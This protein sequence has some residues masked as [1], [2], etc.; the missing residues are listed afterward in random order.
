[1]APIMPGIQ[2]AQL[3]V[4]VGH[5]PSSVNPGVSEL[6]VLA[7]RHVTW[8]R[9]KNRLKPGDTIVGQGRNHTY[10]FH[11]TQCGIACRDTGV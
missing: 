8:F 4:A 3:N 2:D 1:M 9:N 7:G 5:L 6:S 11:V 10:T